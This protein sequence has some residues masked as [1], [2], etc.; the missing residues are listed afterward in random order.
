MKKLK[1]ALYDFVKKYSRGVNEERIW[2][3]SETLPDEVQDEGMY[4]EALSDLVEKDKTLTWRLPHG[5]SDDH[6]RA[7]DVPL[8]YQVVSR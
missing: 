4:H 6:P 5:M 7:L 3:F 2:K 1:Q 8:I